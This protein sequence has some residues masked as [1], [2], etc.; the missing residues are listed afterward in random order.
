MT[1]KKEKELKAAEEKKKQ[2]EAEA[3]AISGPPPLKEGRGFW[4]DG[5]C[6]FWSGGGCRFWSGGGGS[7][8]PDQ[9]AVAASDQEPSGDVVPQTELERALVEYPADR[10]TGAGVNRDLSPEEV[11]GI[12]TYV[13]T[14]YGRAGPV[15]KALPTW[16]WRN[17]FVVALMLRLSHHH[18]PLKYF[19]L[20]V[21]GVVQM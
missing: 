14:A 20:M 10:V 21:G 15:K 18:F 17:W 2:A 3:A 4:W 16:Q 1:T 6:R 13:H 5:G 9:G 7:A 19:V 8:A 11:D 12:M